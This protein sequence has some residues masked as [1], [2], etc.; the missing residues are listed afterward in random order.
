MPVAQHVG[1]QVAHVVGGH[2]AA[3]AQQRQRP[4]RLDQPDR[5][6][7]LAPNSISGAMSASPC[8]AGWRVAS[9]SATA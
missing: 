9:A 3:P 1:G 6:A 2:V 7:G 8:S 4:R 5:P